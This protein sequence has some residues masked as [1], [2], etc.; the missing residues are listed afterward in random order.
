MLRMCMPSRTFIACS[1]YCVLSV[2][3]G[4]ACSTPDLSGP[5]TVDP[6]QLP[7][8][9]SLNTHAITMSTVAPYDTLQLTAVTR[10]AAGDS[11]PEASAPT[12]TSSDSSVRVSSTG[13][14]TARAVQSQVQIVASVVAHGVLVSDTALV[15]VTNEAQPPILE[16]LRVQLQPGDSAQVAAPENFYGVFFYGSQGVAFYKTVLIGALD[17]TG[18]QIPNALVEMST[19]DTTQFQVSRRSLTG[20]ITTETS[21]SFEVNAHSQPGTVATVYANATVYGITRTD[22]LRFLITNPLFYVFTVQKT[23]RVGNT[24]PVWTITTQDL[25]LGVGGWVWWNNPDSTAMLDIVFDDPTAAFPDSVAL[26]SGGG[27]IAPFQG[28]Y[29]DWLPFPGVRSRQFRRAGDFHFHSDR[30]GVSGTVRVR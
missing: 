7:W 13:L 19:S 23:P 15:N 1:A 10:T 30:T 6:A 11:L 29:F 17:A 28:A 27:D 2:M 3:L 18:I 21:Y 24:T 22:S 14:L 16:H 25:P 20:R 26:N 5:S 12:F 8:D 9:L 4:T